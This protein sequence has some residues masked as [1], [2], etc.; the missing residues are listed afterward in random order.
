MP[1]RTM[2]YCHK[3]TVDVYEWVPLRAK[4]KRLL[5]WLEEVVVPMVIEKNISVPI[6][7]LSVVWFSVLHAL[8]TI[9]GLILM[10]SSTF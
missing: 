1:L 4:I 5:L 8:H 9:A 7:F 3:T 10:E 6:I 2:K